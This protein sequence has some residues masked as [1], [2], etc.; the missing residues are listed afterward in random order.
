MIILENNWPRR[1][2]A[3][4]A[5]TVHAKIPAGFYTAVLLSL[6]RLVPSDPYKRDLAAEADEALEAARSMP[7]GREKTEALKKAGLLRK[8]ADAQ[9][10]SKLRQSTHPSE[11][12]AASCR[13]SGGSP[14]RG[15]YRV[16]NPKEHDMRKFHSIAALCGD[17]LRPELQ[18]LFDRLA[19][20][21]HSELFIRRDGMIHWPDPVSE[22]P[23]V[24]RATPKKV[25]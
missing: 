11:T 19:V 24:T 10:I 14:Q 17:G 16:S 8:A 25:A 2:A 4:L 15:S 7:S 6:R 18:A 1:R 22:A 20:D 21:P 23:D 9:G 13:Q 5:Q 12:H 3:I